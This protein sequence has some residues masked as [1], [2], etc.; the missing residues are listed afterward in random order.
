M[1]IN[2]IQKDSQ[3]KK[4]WKNFISKEPF[5]SFDTEYCAL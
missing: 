5:N 2:F 4:V 3:E 1:L